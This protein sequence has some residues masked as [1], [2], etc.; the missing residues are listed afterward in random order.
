MGQLTD[1]GLSTAIICL[2][3]YFI[4]FLARY[5]ATKAWIATKNKWVRGTIKWVGSMWLT[6][7]PIIIGWFMLHFVSGIPVPEMIQN[8]VGDHPHSPVLGIYG[9][10]CGMISGAVVKAVKKVLEKK[11]I[12]VTL[13][14]P[15]EAA[16]AAKQA[17]VDKT[18]EK[19]NDKDGK[20]EKA[21]TPPEEESDSTVEDGKD[22]SND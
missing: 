10:F 19:I 12:D 13:D 18:A 5:I 11:G 3:V 20:E 1:I 4:V 21:E 7:W 2:G 9:A 14:D 15:A 22:S 16:L 17:C 8:L 6:I